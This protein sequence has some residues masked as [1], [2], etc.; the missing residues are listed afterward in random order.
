MPLRFNFFGPETLYHRTKSD[1]K[2]IQL[3]S[4]Y[5]NFSTGFSEKE[6]WC[7]KPLSLAVTLIYGFIFTKQGYIQFFLNVIS[8]C[9]DIIKNMS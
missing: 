9:Q 8:L 4:K 1:K 5:C 3:C 6:R 7:S 2:K